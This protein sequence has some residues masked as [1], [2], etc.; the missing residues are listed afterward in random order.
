MD[1]AAQVVDQDRHVHV[2]FIAQQAGRLSLFAHGAVRGDNFSG[3]CFPHIDEEK[4]NVI[5]AIAIVKLV[6]F[7]NGGGGHGTGSG[8]KNQK[9]ILFFGIVA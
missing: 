5:A 2:F 9:N 8:A 3:V 6:D 4:L 1:G 7:A